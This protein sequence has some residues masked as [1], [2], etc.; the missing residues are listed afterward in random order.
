MYY[1]CTFVENKNTLCSR[2]YLKTKTFKGL[3]IT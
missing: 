3:K 2:E 1:F